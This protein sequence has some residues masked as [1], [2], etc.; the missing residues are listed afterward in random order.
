MSAITVITD[1][2]RQRMIEELTGPDGI[3]EVTNQTIR[4]VDYRVFK[5]SPRNLREMY[6]LG[7]DKDSFYA[8]VFIN[9]FGD[10]DWPCMIYRNECY[11]FEEAYQ[12]AAQLA[13]RM[14]ERYGIEKGDRVAMAMR[15]YPEFCLAFMASTAIGAMAV[16]FNAWWEGPELA[17]GLKDSEPKLVFADQQRADRLVPY[18]NEFKIPVVVARPEKDLP[19]G[20]IRYQDLIAGSTEKD[21]PPASVDMDDDAYIMYT[22]GSTGRPKGVVTTHRA[23]INT[24][25]SWHFPVI[26]LLHLNRDY[27]DE[28]KPENKPSTILTVPLFHVTGLISQFL[29]NFI[30]KRKMVMLYKWDPE[31]ALRLIEKEHITQFNGVPSMSWEMVNS[32]NLRKY[33]LSSL[34]VMGGGGAARPPQHVKIL[35]QILGRHISQAGYGLTETTAI[36]ATNAGEPYLTHPDSV[37]RPT[38]PL[39]EAK[40]VDEQ[41]R[42]LKN[43]EIG[44]ICFKS[45]ANLKEYWKDPQATADIFLEDGWLKT[46]DVGI[47]DDEGFIYIKDRA[48]DLVIRGGE[49]IA[50]REVEDAIYEHPKVFEAAVFGLPEERLGEQVA[51]V[52]MVRQGERLTEQELKDFLVSRLARFKIPSLIWIQEEPLPRGGTGK[53]YKKGLREEKLNEFIKTNP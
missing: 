31:E 27:L 9:W 32:P 29:A 3:F 26:G 22:S 43:G 1:E 48:K 12:L 7:M 53:L 15:N 44:E 45:P 46:G 4:G 35:E 11:S 19:D 17:Y 10:Q 38:L 23:V 52:I 21:F 20:A 2:V 37:G 8:R 14:K 36:G 24:V 47:M 5:S 40:I 41:G 50:C 28:V 49:N 13:W 25:M 34:T 18:L 51:A 16:P 39:V 6:A 33:D 30:I 42:T